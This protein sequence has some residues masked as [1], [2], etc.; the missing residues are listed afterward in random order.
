MKSVFYHCVYQQKMKIDSQVTLKSGKKS[1]MPKR[2]YQSRERCHPQKYNAVSE[3]V[4]L[5]GSMYDRS[6]N[7][8]TLDYTSA[9]STPSGKTSAIKHIASSSDTFTLTRARVERKL[10]KEK[11]CSKISMKKPSRIFCKDPNKRL[12]N[13]FTIIKPNEKFN[14]NPCLPSSNN[15][16]L[17]NKTKELLVKLIDNELQRIQM[18]DD[19]NKNVKKIPDN[20]IDKSVLKTLKVECLRKIEDELRLLKRLARY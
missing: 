1:C 18:D 16:D 14:E 17:L 10:T 3:S 8:N 13:L 2:F 20:V 19:A 7:Y 15:I 11:V 9:N 6:I 12:K 5:V 4:S